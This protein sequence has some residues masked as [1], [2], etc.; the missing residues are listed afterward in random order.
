MTDASPAGVDAAVAAVL[1][2]TTAVGEHYYASAEAA[3]LTVQEARLLFIL[4][5]NPSNMLGLRSALRVPKSTMTGLMARMEDAGLIVRERDP[6]DRRHFVATPT[7]EGV[8]VAREFASNLGGRVAPLLAT[9]DDAD[10][11]ELAGILGE[12]LAASESVHA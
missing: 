8:R 2:A 5:L 12:L 10:S 11:H 9:L 6:R 4:S 7:A 3:G 1:R